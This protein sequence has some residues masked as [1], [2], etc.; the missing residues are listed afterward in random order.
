[1]H[2]A[3]RRF[4]EL[5]MSSVLL[6]PVGQL[7]FILQSHIQ[8][9]SFADLPGMALIHPPERHNDAAPWRQ[10]HGRRRDVLMVAAPHGIQ[11]GRAHV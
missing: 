11:I 3:T 7:R 10:I 1:M 9:E 8:L 6:Q 5:G 4:G 2:S